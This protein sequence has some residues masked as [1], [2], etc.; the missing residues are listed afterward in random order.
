M[1]R[2]TT[3]RVKLDHTEEIVSE[4]A[5]LEVMAPLL[6]DN[7]PKETGVAPES[8]GLRQRVGK[9]RQ[10]R[11]ELPASVGTDRSWITLLS[12]PEA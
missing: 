4:L 3:G 12:T 10:S 6:G 2:K 9:R 5:G 8:A 1:E 11:R 7:Y